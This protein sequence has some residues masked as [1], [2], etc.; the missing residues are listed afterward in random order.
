MQKLSILIRAFLCFMLHDKRC[1][2]SDECGDIWPPETIPGID[3]GDGVIDLFDYYEAV[4]IHLGLVTPTPCQLQRGDM[5]MV[6]H[7]IVP[8]VREMVLL[9]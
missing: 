1:L 7:P 4:D 2:C 6:N 5:P 8:T 9:I 3:C